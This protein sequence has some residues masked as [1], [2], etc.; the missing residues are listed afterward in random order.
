MS[1]LDYALTTV[2][3]AKSYIGADSYSDEDDTFIENI[4]NI[5]TNQ[6]E[7]YTGRRF[8]KTS[9]T[10]EEHDGAVGDSF[11]LDNY[12]VFSDE[13]FTLQYRDSVSN[14]DDWESEDS[15]DY[16]VY[17][18]E[19]VVS[20]I[21]DSSLGRVRKHWR[22]SY[23]AGYDF[24][25]SSTFLGDTKAG[26]LELA[27]WMMVSDMFYKR[28][29]GRS[30]E[31][32]KLGDYSVKYGGDL[33]SYFKDGSGQSVSMVQVTLDKYKRFESASAFTPD[34]Y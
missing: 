19:G 27:T 4:I 13:T 16:Y 22:V 24:D 3:R 5:I 29:D 9:Y 32:E 34:I 12:P 26:D 20:L 17:Y 23:T 15:E 18:D 28:S 25:N 14:E 21:A 33:G 30:V 7:S 1:L 6:I 8:K 2:D 10:N 31:S 11:L